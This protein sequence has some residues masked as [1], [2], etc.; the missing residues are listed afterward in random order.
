[1]T[2]CLPRKT[3]CAAMHELSICQ[4]LLGEVERVATA[5]ASTEVNRIFVAVGPLSGVDAPLLARAFDVARMGTIAERAVLEIETLPAVVWCRACAV[6]T[7]VAA[8]S[9]LCSRCGTWHVEL[10][11]GAELLLT[12]ME[13]TGD[14]S[15]AAAAG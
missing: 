2:R 5:N 10:K 13:L 9:L 15:P 4:S 14:A 6:E 11:S 8:N 3:K 1:M 7:P 12:R